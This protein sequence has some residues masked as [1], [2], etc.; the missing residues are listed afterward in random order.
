MKYLKHFFPSIFIITALFTFSLGSNY[1]TI[2]LFGFSAFIIL[3]DA[4]LKKQTTVQ[5]FSYPSILNLSIYINLPFLFIL[6]F[7]VVFIFSSYSPIWFVNFYDKFLFIDLINIKS[8]ATLLDKISI[9]ITTTLFIGILG[10]VPGH[11]LTHRKKNKLDMFIG[12]WMLAFSWDCAFAIEHVYGHHK[13]VGLPQDPATAKRGENL[14]GFILR[15][16]FKQQIVAWKIE[17]ARLKRRKHHLLS[18]HNKMIV[19]Y[20][21]S[22]I[23]TILAFYIG[24]LIGMATFL[25]CAFLAKALLETI[26]YSEHYGLVRVEGEGVSTRH[27]WNSNH[28]MSGIMLCNV[29][30]HSSHHHSTNLKFWELDTLPKAPMLPHGYLAMLYI[31]IFLP[32]LYHKMMAKKLIDWDLNYASDKEKKL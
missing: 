16:I 14:Y 19:G 9:I 8:T 30:R 27:S 1:P 26:N 10:T 15:A 32:F 18:L 13:Y 4:L 22:I 3:G 12:N 21:R 25:L 17:L 28:A 24:G 31:A 11:E 5:K 7:F 29:N 6:I 2:F 20:F 23:I